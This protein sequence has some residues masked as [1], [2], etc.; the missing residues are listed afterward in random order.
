MLQ[1][2]G[3]AR[4]GGGAAADADD[5][6]GNNDDDGGGGRRSRKA[7]R[8]LEQQ[9]RNAQATNRDDDGA[10]S[11]D[12][13]DDAPTPT[14]TKKLKHGG[15]DP[16]ALKLNDSCT[17]SEDSRDSMVSVYCS[18]DAST[19]DYVYPFAQFCEDISVSQERYC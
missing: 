1:L 15:K 2:G 16:A 7:A 19:T 11:D 18:H 13:D 17:W 8:K 10:T 12:D 5:D 6:D 9:E 14:P 4:A 3:G